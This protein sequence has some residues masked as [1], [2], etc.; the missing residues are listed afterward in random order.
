LAD[1][2]YVSWLDV[3]FA[4]SG[5]DVFLPGGQLFLLVFGDSE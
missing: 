5:F 2:E 1:V 4:N 3:A